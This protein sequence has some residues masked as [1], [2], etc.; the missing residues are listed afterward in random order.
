MMAMTTSSSIKV[1]PRK[2]RSFFID[3]TPHV[4]KSV[5][6]RPPQASQ[7]GRTSNKVAQHTIEDCESRIGPADGTEERLDH[8]LEISTLRNT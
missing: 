7:P 5:R 4:E 6:R 1:K 3:T 8:R 2:P